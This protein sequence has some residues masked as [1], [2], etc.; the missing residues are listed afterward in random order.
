M[1]GRGYLVAT[2]IAAFIAGG[3]AFF[4]PAPRLIWNATASTPTGLYAL[5]ARAFRH[6]DPLRFG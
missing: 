2:C 1:T 5:L 4:Q 6:L 3:L